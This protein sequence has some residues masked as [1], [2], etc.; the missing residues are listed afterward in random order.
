MNDQEIIRRLREVLN[1]PDRAQ[2]VKLLRS[3]SIDGGAVRVVEILSARS[4]LP[5]RADRQT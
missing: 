3:L 5:L 1:E 2:Q 4:L